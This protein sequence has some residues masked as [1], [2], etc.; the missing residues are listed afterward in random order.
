M[1]FKFFIG[2]KGTLLKGLKIEKEDRSL[3]LLSFYPNKPI[4]EHLI[5]ENSS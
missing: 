1:L 4:L 2:E 3:Y 5:D